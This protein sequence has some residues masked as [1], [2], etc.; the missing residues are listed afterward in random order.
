M[1]K[2]ILNLRNKSYE[3]KKK[4]NSYPRRGKGGAMKRLTT[5]N[6]LLIILL[7]V[8]FI[9]TGAGLSGCTMKPKEIKIGAILPL[10]GP[11]GWI[12]ELRKMG[13][14]LATEEINS[15]GG[16][17]GKRLKIIYEDD[18]NEPLQAVNAF[19]KLVTTIHPPAIMVA[20]SASGMAVRPL[21]K[22]TKTVLFADGNHPELVKGNEWVFRVFLTSEQEAEV[23]AKVTFKDLGLKKVAVLYIDDASG[24]GGK[25]VFEKYYTELGGKIPI[26]EKYDKNGTDFRAEIAKILPLKT[27]AVYVIGY[28]NA[29]G[30]LLNQLIELGYKGKILGT[31]NFGGPPLT[32]IAPVPLEG[33]IFTT[34][35]FDPRIPTSK[36]KQ[37][38]DKIKARYGKEPYWITATE[39][40]AIYI[41]KEAMSKFSKIDG[42]HLRKALFE[43]TEF[44]GAAG[45]YEYRTREW[46]PD[47]TIRTYKNGELRPYE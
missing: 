17:N 15:Q 33:S 39:Y 5:N 45:K 23:M 43:V 37:F 46:L 40:D 21:A 36:T 18:R 19:R 25:N 26:A 38:I 31:M 32:E 3:R 44:E 11:A 13:F 16:I 10:S 8:V 22:E 29:A 30:K 12:G 6:R 20:M 4:T 35:F 2:Q 9:I 1:R 24:E 42:E 47:L 28:G 14:D 34:P 41:I 7:T 27:E